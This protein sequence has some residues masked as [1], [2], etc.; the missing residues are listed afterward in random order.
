MDSSRGWPREII[1]Y[2]MATMQMSV[3]YF[4]RWDI[5][6]PERDTYHIYYYYRKSF[7]SSSRNANSVDS[8][9]SDK[10]QYP[11]ISLTWVLKR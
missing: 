1:F 7:Q 8:K 10:L 9:N 2:S 4:R 3:E 5:T 6:T 11:A